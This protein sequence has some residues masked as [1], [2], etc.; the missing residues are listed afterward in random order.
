MQEAIGLLTETTHQVAEEAGASALEAAGKLAGA[1]RGLR[2]L[3][4]I[5]GGNLT[6]EQ[7]RRALGLA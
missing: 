3:L 1:L 5:T 4:P 2:V 6:L 7:L